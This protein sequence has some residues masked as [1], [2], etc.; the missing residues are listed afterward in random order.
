MKR[1]YTLQ[2]VADA[3]QIPVTT[4]RL[5]VREGK[6]E[7]VKLGR[8]YRVTTNSIEQMMLQFAKK[9]DLQNINKYMTTDRDFTYMTTDLDY[10]YMDKNKMYTL[11]EI[12][13]ALQIPISTIR[14]Y[15]REGKLLAIKIGKRHMV[16][17]KNTNKLIH[18]CGYF[19]DKIVEWTD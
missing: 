11:Q 5:Y 7:A 19:Q 9:L 12:A 13:D 6:L 3:L 10:E 15:V 4:I 18:A 8:C 17:A 1:L 2:D 16:K 14:L